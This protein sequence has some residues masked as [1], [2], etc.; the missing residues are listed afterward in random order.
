MAGR[1]TP[2]EASAIATY[3]RRTAMRVLLAIDGSGHS[4]AA[5]A[6]VAR[7]HVPAPGEV[8]IVSVIEASFFPATFA[9]DGGSMSL[10]ADIERAAN[11]RAHAAVDKAAVTLLA[12]EENRQLKV[13]TGVLSG[14]ASRAILD[15]ADAFGAD[16]IVVGSH[17]HGHFKRFVLG[18]VSQAV[19]L[20]A[21]CSVEIVRTPSTQPSAHTSQ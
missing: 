2:S 10:Y 17:G 7:R 11:E 15:E 6:E 5:V 4:D 18:S 16:L 1:A 21:N 12:D 3:E 14:S 9:G 8:R 19:A 13:T 20:H